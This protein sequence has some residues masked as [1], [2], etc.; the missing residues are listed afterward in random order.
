MYVDSPVLDG[1]V[2]RQGEGGHMHLHQNILAAVVLGTVDN[3]VKPFL[4]TP[5][6][7]D[8]CIVAELLRSISFCVNIFVIIIN[9]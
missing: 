4:P 3:S 2:H 9:I 1:Q 5:N 6:P 8:V 7:K